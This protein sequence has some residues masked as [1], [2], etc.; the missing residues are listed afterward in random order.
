MTD[1]DVCVRENGQETAIAAENLDDSVL[2]DL[3]GEIPVACIPDGFGVE[4]YDSEEKA[5][6]DGGELVDRTEL[7]TGG[8][9]LSD[10]QLNAVMALAGLLLAGSGWEFATGSEILA[11][12]ALLSGFVLAWVARASLRSG[13]A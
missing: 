1:G 13:R 7:E 4:Y 2:L 8:F 5:L 11:L 12:V 3:D 6:T 10:D 9:A